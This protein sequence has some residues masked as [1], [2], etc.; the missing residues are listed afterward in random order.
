MANNNFHALPLANLNEDSKKRKREEN[1]R[2]WKW[3]EVVSSDEDSTDQKEDL[4]EASSDI[5]KELYEESS[6][7][8]E[9]Y[10]ED[11]SDLEEY[12]GMFD[13][14]DQEEVCLC[15][16]IDNHEASFVF[17]FVFANDNHEPSDVC[18]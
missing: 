4:H 18:K 17:L 9:F 12:L 13:E 3:N 7:Q 15:F 8:E 16:A 1:L 6:D 11:S 2:T 10:D 5:E 14:T